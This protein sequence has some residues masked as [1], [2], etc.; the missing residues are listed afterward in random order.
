MSL[1]VTTGISVLY[2][3]K[4]NLGFSFK[5]TWSVTI[6]LR[7]TFSVEEL[8]KST[9]VFTPS[10]IPSSAYPTPLPIPFSGNWTPTY[11]KSVWL[12]TQSAEGISLPVNGDKS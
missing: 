3:V 1:V 5:S 4:I 7:S 2:R 8:S 11:P 6:V 12:I 9:T 10:N